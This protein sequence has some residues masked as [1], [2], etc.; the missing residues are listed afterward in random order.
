MLVFVVPLTVSSKTSLRLLP[1]MP[2]PTIPC[3]CQRGGV[4]S[5]S[6]SERFYTQFETVLGNSW[7]IYFPSAP[8]RLYWVYDIYLAMKFSTITAISLASL[9]IVLLW[10][11]FVV[12]IFRNWPQD[13]IESKAKHTGDRGS[14]TSST[15]SSASHS[16]RYKCGDPEIGEGQLQNASSAGEKIRDPSRGQDGV[17]SDTNRGSGIHSFAGR[18][19][20]DMESGPL[21]TPYGNSDLTT[22]ESFGLEEPFVTSDPA[23]PESPPRPSLAL[24]P[25]SPS[26]S[27]YLVMDIHLTPSESSRTPRTI[28]EL[29]PQTGSH[30]PSHSSTF[31]KRAHGKY[32]AGFQ[33]PHYSVASSSSQITSIKYADDLVHHR[34][35]GHTVHLPPDWAR[36]HIRNGIRPRPVDRPVRPTTTAENVADWRTRV[37]NDGEAITP[38]RLRDT[39][40]D[41]SGFGR[42]DEETQET[43]IKIVVSSPAQCMAYLH[44]EIECPILNECATCLPS[45]S[46][47][48]KNDGPGKFVVTVRLYRFADYEQHKQYS[49]IQRK[50]DE[51]EGE[52]YSHHA[53]EDAEQHRDDGWVIGDA[54]HIVRRMILFGESC[55]VRNSITG[56][57]VGFHGLRKGPSLLEPAKTGL[58]LNVLENVWEGAGTVS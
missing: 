6:T 40:R 23:T 25:E 49:M 16:F 31:L 56:D 7:N 33:S 12:I 36:Q 52:R 38:R 1:T 17:E 58:K 11:L 27:Y 50:H 20:E 28:E 47:R 41:K 13:S 42:G 32:A 18:A 34:L 46:S 39:E 29:E 22:H 54:G 35:T 57:G 51:N 24:C 5:D 10:C 30:R 14:T 53:V 19:Y 21:P 15:I 45:G 48:K 3:P 8:W 9:V 37:I 44:S 2:T 26:S 55:G 4:D 43:K